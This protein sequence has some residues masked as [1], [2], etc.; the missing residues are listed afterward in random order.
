M[1]SQLWNTMET[2]SYEWKEGSG[3]IAKRSEGIDTEG[4]VGGN[5]GKLFGGSC[6]VFALLI[7]KV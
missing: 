2:E 3:E 6:C 5:L 7:D 4:G 1:R